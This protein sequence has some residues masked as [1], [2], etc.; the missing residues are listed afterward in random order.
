MGRPAVGPS[1]MKL[2]DKTH[3]QGRWMNRTEAW[4]KQT[5]MPAEVIRYIVERCKQQN[6]PEDV[7]Q[8]FKQKVFKKP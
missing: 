3:F 4:V 8:F 2:T 6:A 5:E 7:Q 1:D